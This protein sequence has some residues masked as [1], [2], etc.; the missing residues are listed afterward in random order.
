MGCFAFRA[1]VSLATG[2][3]LTNATFLASKIEDFA[4][5]LPTNAW[6]QRRVTLEV[7]G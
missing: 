7:S 5:T 3:V 6:R 1:E 2:S 4:N